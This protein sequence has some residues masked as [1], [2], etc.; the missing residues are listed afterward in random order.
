MSS[1]NTR[2]HSRSQDGRACAGVYDIQDSGE[3][4]VFITTVS[5]S[6]IDS[7]INS[8][9]QVST[10]S[11]LGPDSPSILASVSV[12]TASDSQNQQ[13]KHQSPLA[14]IISSIPAFNVSQISP[15]AGRND[16]NIASPSG[17]TRSKK[18][19][20]VVVKKALVRVKRID[21]KW[22][23][24]KSFKGK[25][26]IE[27]RMFPPSLQSRSPLE[28]FRMFFDDD[29]IELIVQQTN[30]Y[31]MQ[32]KSTPLNVTT[33]EIRDLIAIHLLMG[34]VNMPAYT[35][36]WCK[37]LRYNKIANI[38]PLKRFQQIR[39]YLHFANNLQDDGDRYFKV[40][41]LLES[42]R[43]NCLKIE[44]ENRFSIDEVMVPYKGTRAG[45]RKQY[46]KNKPRKWGFK[47]F[48]R[49]GVSGI[50]YDFLA[51]GGEDTF[52]YHD[53]TEDENGMGL[54]AKVVLAL[55]KTIK[56]QACS[57]LYFDNFFTSLELLK[58][59]R[60][61]YGIF[62]L[63]TI[64]QNR[65]RGAAAKLPT[66][67]NLKKRGRGSFAQVI[68]NECKI[69]VIKWFDTKCVTAASTY[70]H[71]Q[72]VQQVWRYCKKTK[73][74]NPVTCPNI[75]KEY[76]NN[77]GGVDLA[78]MLV[79]LYRTEMRAHRWYI[80]LC[81][82]LLDICVNNAWLIYR[83]ENKGKKH[84]KLKVFRCAISN[85]LNTFQRTKEIANTSRGAHFVTPQISD[86]GRLDQIGH[87]PSFASKGRCKKCIKSQTKFICVKCNVR[88]CLVEGRN[89]FF[90]YH[91]K[92]A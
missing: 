59:L 86:Y 41:N 70:T 16:F 1:G 44:E 21:T 26:D 84:M 25:A 82:Q 50:I 60:N 33:D 83:R 49:A 7:N 56:Q 85:D 73:S 34:V 66:D 64:R 23:C 28:Y 61:E 57:V 36:Y 17:G 72:P 52:R 30:L 90:D 32:T 6:V 27:V 9:H 14:T 15:L 80:P 87:M 4:T 78:D 75:I 67:K 89:C 76:N 92:S 58:H 42:I 88:L 12:P 79:A 48:V 5:S 45:S 77:M 68:P 71:S 20:T 29:L 11:Y 10:P 65:L 46:I 13:I 22:T 35:D 54:G 38:M 24:T 37:T 53:F 91:T 55:S 31:H 40:R 47:V 2:T 81:S 51:Y 19:T 18:K 3:D 39:R 69:A 8:C 43:R 74:R 63:G 62:A